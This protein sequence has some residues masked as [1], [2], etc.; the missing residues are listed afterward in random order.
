MLSREDNEKLT[1]TGPGTPMGEVFRRYW[2]PA[3]MSS[4]L[5]EPDG[6]PVRVRLLGESLIAFRDTT[7][8][9]GLVDAF[10]PHRRA[11]MFFGR[12]EECGIRCVY[13]GWKFDRHGTCVD[14]PSEPP[15]SLFKTKVTIP[16]YPTWEGGGIVWAYLG[17]RDRQ[18]PPPDYELVRAPE[19]HRFV[20]KT[21]QQCNYLQA[22]EGGLDSVHA[23]IMHRENI[24]DRSWLNDYE[25]TVPRIDVERKDYGYMYSGIRNLG[26][27][28][29]VRAY[30]YIM[31]TMQMRGNF[32]GVFK[33]E[34]MPKVDGH[35]WIPIDDV[36]CFVYN[37]M[38][39]YDASTPIPPDDAIED[40]EMYGRGRNVLPDFTTKWNMS[41]DYGIDR[42]KQRAHSFTG[43]EGI[44]TQDTALQEGMGPI[45]DRTKEHLGTTDR[46]IIA[47]RQLLLEATRAVET[48]GAPRGVDPQA[49]RTVRPVDHLIAAGLDWRT[50]L[51]GEL[52]AKF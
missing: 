5:V 51:A 1:R 47:M 37:F 48:G 36:T 18:P 22:L 50:A 42:A 40:E 11:P 9:V 52:A 27:E 21:I 13:H 8:A 10:C 19:T 25:R 23:T 41:N 12:N 38:Y 35:I 16:N 20:S 45:V 6:P 44:N 14:M 26:T 32:Q 49:Y 34:G 46:A 2:V 15:D 28:Q 39:S 3:A 4:E 31:P 29:W 30:Q 33:R 17:P 24:G 43:I 7:G